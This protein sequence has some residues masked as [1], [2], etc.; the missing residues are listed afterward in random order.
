MCTCPE[1]RR[2]EAALYL[3]NSSPKAERRDWTKETNSR[4]A[5]AYG[6]SSARGT[7]GP[8]GSRR[9]CRIGRLGQ[10]RAKLK[11][12]KSQDQQSQGRCNRT[13]DRSG[14]RRDPTMTC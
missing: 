4:Q 7:G 10:G 8:N 9:H 3:T 2:R 11:P 12:S 6:R 13:H 14:W 1:A 5:K